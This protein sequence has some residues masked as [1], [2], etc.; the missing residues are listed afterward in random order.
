METRMGR[1]IREMQIGRTKRMLDDGY[2][3]TEI[4]E[5]LKVDEST[6]RSYKEVIER[7]EKNMA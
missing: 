5:K 6:V 4:A 7:A 3:V 2:S 1:R